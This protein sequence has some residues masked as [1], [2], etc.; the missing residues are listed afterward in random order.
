LWTS[1][2]TKEA[3]ETKSARIDVLSW[4]SK[5]TLDVIGLAGRYPLI[6]II[7]VFAQLNFPSGFNYSFNALNA[8]DKPNELNEAFSKLFK[9]ANSLSLL[10]VLQ[11]WFPVFR[12][13][14]R[15][16]SP[17]LTTHFQ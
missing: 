17:L 12:S 9:V 2:I 8:E 7:K 16:L 4:L 3:S 1:E 11:A 6:W 14:V 13:L 15:S 5:M 10:P